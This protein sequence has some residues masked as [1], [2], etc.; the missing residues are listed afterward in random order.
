MGILGS[1]DKN[2]SSNAPGEMKEERRKHVE[3]LGREFHTVKDGL[4]PE[5]VINF[6]ETIAGSSEAAF[7]RLDQFTAFQSVAKTMEES[8]LEA[9]Q[10][11]EHAKA[12]ARL[13][14]QNERTKATE[15]VEQHVSAILEQTRNSCVAS[16]DGIHTVLLEAVTRTE[17][18]QRE[19]LGKVRGMIANNLAEIH[20]DIQNAMAGNSY[21]ADTSIEVS[22]DVPHLP[23]NPADTIETTDE[24]D[25]E[26]VEPDEGPAFDLANLQ[27]SLLSLEASMSNLNQSKNAFEH[28]P[29][30]PVAVLDE[31]EDDA[32]DN[33]EEDDV[34]DESDGPQDTVHAYSGEVTVEITGG[35][36][37]PWMQELR[38]RMQDIPGARIRAESGVDERTTMVCL[39]LNEPVKLFPILLS[40]PRVN[41]VIPGRLNGGSADKNRLRLWPKS[42]KESREDTITVELSGNGSVERS[43]VESEDDL[44]SAG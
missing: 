1:K 40:L 42:K 26:E 22:E 19:A 17:K 38:E 6:L 30:T 11:V 36:E 8:I 24:N 20:Q 16:V 44:I 28:T 5:E 32:E 10:L 18:I 31:E 7:K 41:R 34:E 4:D 21:R 9:R 39:S 43:M 35:A 12:Q 14:A 15:E 29:E 33:E 3:M 27:E 37:E 13:E 23:T 2:N 25:I